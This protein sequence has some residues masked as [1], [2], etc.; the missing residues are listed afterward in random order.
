MDFGKY[1]YDHEEEEDWLLAWSDMLDKHKLTDNKWLKKVFKVKQK[2][3]M[4]YRC[5]NFTVDKVSIQ[6]S[7]SMN[8][9]LKRCLKG[10]FDLLTFLNTMRVLDDRRYK[11]LV[12]DFCMMH[13][14][15]VLVAYV[16]MLQH[17]GELYTPEV[18]TLFHMKYT[19][20]SDYV[21]KNANK[22]EMV[23]KYDVSYRGAAR[24]HFFNYDD[25]N[26]TIHCS[27]MK[28]SFAG[29]LCCHTL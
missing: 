24:E 20:I 7:E 18:F 14:S 28:F 3:A 2:W 12:V 5:H 9:I 10:N 21:A 22:S 15:P 11:E 25:V 8:S 17:A 13:T 1:V 23:Y 16:E 4:V 6:H 27:C 29:I 26:Q 19:V